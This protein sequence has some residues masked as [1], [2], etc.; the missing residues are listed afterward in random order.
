MRE[1]AVCMPSFR[2]RFAEF[3]NDRN[4]SV[5]AVAKGRGVTRMNSIYRMARQGDEP[6]RVDLHVLAEVIAELRA[7]TGENVEIG[8][9]LEFVAD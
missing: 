7:L 1:N 3:L 5:Y 9:L 6:Q 4:L 8:D 2:W